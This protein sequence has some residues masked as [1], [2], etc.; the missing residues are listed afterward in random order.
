MTDVS[1]CDEP[2]EGEAPGTQNYF[3]RNI[4]LVYGGPVLNN[5]CKSYLIL[6]AFMHQHRN[7]FV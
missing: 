7:A 3:N 6:E 2:L 1:V 5:L 4:L